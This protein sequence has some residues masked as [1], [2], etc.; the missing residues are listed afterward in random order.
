M[1]RRGYTYDFVSDRQLQ[2]V[3]VE[4]SALV[5]GGGARY[6]TVVV[7]ASRYIPLETLSHL[8]MLANQGA[9]VLVL[10]DF[11]ADVPGLADLSNRRDQLRRAIADLRFGSAGADG[12]AEAPVG[13][14]RIFRGETLDALLSRAGIVRESLV[15]HGL[16][17][18]RRRSEQGRFYFVSNTSTVDLDGW[19][20]VGVTAR[21]LVV[22]D[23]MRGSAGGADAPGRGWRP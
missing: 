7:P 14:G 4:G 17:F 21:H 20:P 13:S 18:A 9:S 5:T 15:E 11:A 19:V 2:Q 3:R 6:A 23:P 16:E 1:Q 12:I 22:H 8:V 10:G